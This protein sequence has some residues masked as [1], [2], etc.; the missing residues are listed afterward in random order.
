MLN[1]LGD[2]LGTSYGFWTTMILT[3]LTIVISF[4]AVDLATFVLS[5][6]AILLPAIILTHDHGRD[7]V[8]KIRDEAMH[9]KL[10]ELIRAIDKADDSLQEIEKDAENC[11]ESK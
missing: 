10:D 2:F 7:E 8:A 3:F 5:V 9:K 1:K 11:V 4:V 6:I